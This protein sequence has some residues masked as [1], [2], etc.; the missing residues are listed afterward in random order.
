MCQDRF[1]GTEFIPFYCTTAEAM[2]MVRQTPNSAL[3]EQNGESGLL[4][5]MIGCQYFFQA[6]V[7]HDHERNAIRERP[8]IVWTAGE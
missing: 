7:A 5:M 4:K 6:E 1:G 8:I 2:R 3:F